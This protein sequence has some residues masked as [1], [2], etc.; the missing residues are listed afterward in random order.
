M[1]IEEISQRVQKSIAGMAKG[2]VLPPA[3]LVMLLVLVPML[4]RAL[5]ESS[6]SE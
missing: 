5:V 4:S 2:L 3:L 6:L 1:S